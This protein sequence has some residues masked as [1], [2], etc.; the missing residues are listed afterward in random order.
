MFLPPFLATWIG[1]VLLCQLAKNF[2]SRDQAQKNDKGSFQDSEPEKQMTVDQDFHCL[3]IVPSNQTKDTMDLNLH[4]R[5]PE[6][7]LRIE[8]GAQAPHDERRRTLR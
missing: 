5:V 2:L 3:D 8:N 4:S 7:E 1:T 6:T